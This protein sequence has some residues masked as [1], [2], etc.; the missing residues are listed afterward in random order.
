MAAGLDLVII[1]VLSVFGVFMVGL[2]YATWTT[3]GMPMVPSR[4]TR[5]HA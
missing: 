1:G 4:D 2:G 5:P 3:R